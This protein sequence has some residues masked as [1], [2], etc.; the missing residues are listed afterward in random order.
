MEV[1]K[2]FMVAQHTMFDGKLQLTYKL[3]SADLHVN[4]I[5]RKL[6]WYITLEVVPTQITVLDKP[7]KHSGEFLSMEKIMQHKDASC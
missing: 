7:M 6:I 1:N 2:T 5:R 3:F 4:C